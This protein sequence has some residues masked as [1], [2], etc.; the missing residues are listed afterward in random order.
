MISITKAIDPN[1]E[2]H[3]NDFKKMNTSLAVLTRK[4]TAAED[5]IINNDKRN[6]S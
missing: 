1:C 4:A 3:I 2:M 6:R 5:E